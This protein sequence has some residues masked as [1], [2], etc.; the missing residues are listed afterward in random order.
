MPKQER[1]G[2][3]EVSSSYAT[4]SSSLTLCVVSKLVNIALVSDN[5]VLPRLSIPDTEVDAIF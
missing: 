4:L 2:N 3:D 1:L 5:V